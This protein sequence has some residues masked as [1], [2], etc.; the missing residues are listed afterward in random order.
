MTITRTPTTER[1]EIMVDGKDLVCYV[2]VAAGFIVTDM[3]VDRLMPQSR[4]RVVLEGYPQLGAAD[5]GAQ[6]RPVING[7]RQGVL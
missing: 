2:G 4:N 6:A 7:Q 1:I 5:A 3:L